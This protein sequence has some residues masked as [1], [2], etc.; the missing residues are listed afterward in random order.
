MELTALAKL[1]EDNFSEPFLPKGHVRVRLHTD[2]TMQLYIGPR[3][4]HFDAEG[5][6]LGSGTRVSE[7]CVES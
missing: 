2:N 1:L 7:V 5:N 4:V 6:C 3:D